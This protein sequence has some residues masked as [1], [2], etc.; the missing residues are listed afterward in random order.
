MEIA[1]KS[2]RYW[3]GRTVL[4]ALGWDVEGAAP[5][6][7][8]YVIIAAPHTTNWDMPITLGVAWVLGIDASWVAKH[9]LFRW[10]FGTF[11]KSLGGIPIDRRAKNDQVQQLVDM[12]HNSESMV[13]VIAPEG[14]RGTTGYWKSGFY[15]IARGANVPI[16]LGFLD[17]ARKMGGVGAAFVPGESIE[18]DVARIRAFYASVTARFPERFTNI[19]FRPKAVSA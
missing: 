3:V 16:A 7:T 2:L 18:E 15:H 11:F 6:E 14:T 19:V 4:D 8:K 1:G 12:F 17:Y 13:L 5:T 9:T 10:P